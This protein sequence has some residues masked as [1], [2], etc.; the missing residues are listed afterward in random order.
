MNL[1]SYK[2]LVPFIDTKAIPLHQLVKYSD[3]VTKNKNLNFAHIWARWWDQFNDIMIEMVVTTAK[4]VKGSVDLVGWS[5]VPR[6]WTN[7]CP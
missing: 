4:L 6:D 7:A 2:G 3:S 1:K 5:I